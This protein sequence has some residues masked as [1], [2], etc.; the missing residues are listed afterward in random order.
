[1]SF[2]KVRVPRHV[3]FPWKT[4]Q[5]YNGSVTTTKI[6]K[7]SCR[8]VIRWCNVQLPWKRHILSRRPPHINRDEVLLLWLRKKNIYILLYQDYTK[9]RLHFTSHSNWTCP[10]LGGAAAHRFIQLPLKL[11]LAIYPCVVSAT[12][13]WLQ[14]ANILPFKKVFSS[15]HHIAWICDHFCSCA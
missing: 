15:S 5:V 1:M 2:R 3:K 7:E 9:I 14:E 13:W 10:P 8:H 4:M 12:Y 6:S 11:I